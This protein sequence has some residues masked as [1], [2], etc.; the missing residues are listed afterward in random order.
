MLEALSADFSYNI[1]RLIITYLD[2]I[3]VRLIQ[4]PTFVCMTLSW[5][6]S[7]TMAPV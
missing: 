6:R 4:V 1:Q 5:V 7:T 2:H 3:L